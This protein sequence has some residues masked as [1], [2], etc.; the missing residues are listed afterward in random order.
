MTKRITQ[1]TEF[2][3]AI[4]RHF[5]EL[6]GYLPL[7]WPSRI[8]NCLHVFQAMANFLNAFKN[9]NVKSVAELATYQQILKAFLRP[10][11]ILGEKSLALYT[12][13]LAC[14]KSTDVEQVFSKECWVVR[15]AINQMV[16]M[17]AQLFKT[18]KSI[19]LA[20]KHYPNEVPERLLSEVALTPSPKM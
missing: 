1:K 19:D 3:Q 4:E 18:Q 14:L 7:G 16:D 9:I 11:R 13:F 15:T 12:E 20:I 10:R 17:N 2:V 8:E 6:A 5:P